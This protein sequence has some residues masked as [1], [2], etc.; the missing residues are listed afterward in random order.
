MEQDRDELEIPFSPSTLPSPLTSSPSPSPSSLSP[1]LP[2]PTH[3]HGFPIS[4]T[5]LSSP[6]PTF[7][8]LKLPSHI[9]HRL[10]SLGLHTP[11]LIQSATI[12]HLLPPPP[13][14]PPPP[15]SL[16]PPP[17]PSPDLLISDSSGSG[18][19]LAYA[20][21]LLSSLSPYLHALQ[22]VIL[23]PTRELAQ[24]TSSVLRELGEGGTKARARHP[25]RIDLCVGAV[26][27]SMVAQMTRPLPLPALTA[28]QRGDPAQPP[29]EWQ[30]E[31]E[32][33]GGGGDRCPVPQVIIGTVEVVWDLL[34]KRALLDT[35][36]LRYVV[37]DEA[38]CM[39]LNPA[40]TPMIVDVL[41]LRR[42]AGEGGRR[43]GGQGTQ[44]LLV[45]SVVTPQVLRFAAL[46]LSWHRR[47]L[48]AASVPE[49]CERRKRSLLTVAS[50]TSRGRVVW[51]QRPQL[52]PHVSHHY[53]RMPATVT[54]G[55]KGEMLLQLCMAIRA[56]FL[57]SHAP[58][59][60]AGVDPSHLLTP[61]RRP[62]RRPPPLPRTR[63]RPRW[64]CSAP[65]P[66]SSPCSP[67]S[68]PTSASPCSPP[69]PPAPSAA[70]PSPSTPRPTSSSPTLPSCVGWT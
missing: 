42:E 2:M 21:P 59:R 10:S 29:R 68:P 9:Y 65:P 38:D 66:T 56:S 67:F 33:E 63:H 54:R 69:S 60:S 6:S 16:P 23:T 62:H 15:P 39:L 55:E 35:A 37:V 36:H 26:N 51:G 47:L 41:R 27:P 8:S 70:R 3:V 34:C 5:P 50:T 40:H 19:T 43:D 49:E 44:V 48:T 1:S 52:L 30:A 18:K 45:Q 61:Q 11:T 64:W 32:G 28:A 24:Q 22:A 20:L 53:A 7:A 12:P 58:P 14:P 4:L 17:S 57:A 13:P 31:W 46:H 25:L